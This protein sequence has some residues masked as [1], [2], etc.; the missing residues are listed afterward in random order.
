[1]GKALRTVTLCAVLAACGREPPAQPDPFV[2]IQAELKQ[3]YDL[4]A[5]DALAARVERIPR[6]I[7]LLREREDW[8][9]LS[10]CADALGSIGPAARPA[11][12]A[13]RKLLD[14]DERWVRSSAEDA[15][16]AIEG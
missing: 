7:E 5:E 14:H 13:L 8:L 12:P 2:P 16:E 15:I 1:M 4:F 3:H 6:L 11:L 9:D 10:G